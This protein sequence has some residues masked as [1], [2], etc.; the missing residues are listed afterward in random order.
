MDVR[1]IMT[2]NP[3]SIEPEAPAAAAIDVMA[4]LKIRNLPVRGDC[5][6]SEPPWKNFGSR[7]P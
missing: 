3:I 2:M 6:A 1:D 5:G 7:T 4:E